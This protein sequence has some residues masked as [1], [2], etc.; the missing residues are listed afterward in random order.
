M[1]R[2]CIATPGPVGS[3][4]RVVKEADTLSAAGYDVHVI[5]TRTLDVVDL[6]DDDI[7]ANVAWTS[8]RID[9]RRSLP[10]KALRLLQ[11]AAKGI[12]RATGLAEAEAFSPFA[13][14]LKARILAQKADLYIAHYVATLPLAARAA[15]LHNARYAFDAEDF[16]SGE[17]PDGAA[18]NESIREIEGRWLPGCAYVT[19]ASPGIA[20]AYRETYGVVRPS[21]VL[22]AFPR[23]QAPKAVHPRGTAAPEPTVYWFSQSIG[24]DR[25]LECAVRAVALARTRPHLHLRGNDA[26]GFGA[27]LMRLAASVGAAERVHLLAPAPPHEMEALAAIH[28]VGLVSETGYTRNR[29]IALTNKQFTY[30]LAGL[31]AI[32]SDTPGHIAFAEQAPGA[33]FL[34]KAEDPEDLAQRL[35]MLLE[36]PSRL[37]RARE[38]SF[39]LGQTRFNWETEQT[40]LLERVRLALPSPPS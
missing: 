24:P 40:T 34:Y 39:Q 35:D 10:R 36:D 14:A 6:R 32:M 4:P 23:S 26:Y 13:H 3:N 21:V 22:N 19:A 12:N 2:I 27:E 20:D 11:M 5:S 9:L 25:G 30:F 1:A 28:D 33:A 7:L 37:A 15:R 18:E 8:E 29:Q 16:H 31:P 17:L 38:T